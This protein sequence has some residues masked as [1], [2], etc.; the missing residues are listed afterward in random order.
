MQS[1]SR[2][3]LY[4]EQTESKCWNCYNTTGLAVNI[5]LKCVVQRV[6]KIDAGLVML[7]MSVRVTPYVHSADG[8]IHLVAISRL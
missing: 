6:I 5:E 1:T 7:A 8:L 4:V 3:N 2:G